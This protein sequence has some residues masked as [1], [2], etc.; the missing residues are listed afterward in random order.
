MRLIAAVPPAVAQ[1]TAIHRLML[2]T[3]PQSSRYHDPDA[4]IL[5]AYMIEEPDGPSFTAWVYPDAQAAQ[6]HMQEMWGVAAEAWREVPDQLAGCQDDWIAPVRI[7]RAA[8]GTK[9]YHQW[10]RLVDGE[11]VPFDGPGGGYG[12]QIDPPAGLQ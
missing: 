5:Y 3:N 11:W 2:V 4:V 9:L 8:D 7:A 1:R 10:E 12:L 6:D